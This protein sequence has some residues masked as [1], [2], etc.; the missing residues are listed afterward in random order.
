MRCFNA[1]IRRKLLIA[2]KVESAES[3][4]YLPETI[5]IACAFC[6]YGRLSLIARIDSRTAF[7]AI[8]TLSPAVLKIPEYGTIRTGLPHDNTTRSARSVGMLTTVTEWFDC[9]RIIKSV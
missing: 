5:S 8:I 3:P 7:H 6:K 9:P 2:A 1:V 4:F